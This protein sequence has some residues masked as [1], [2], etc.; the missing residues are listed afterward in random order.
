MDNVRDLVRNKPFSLIR[1]RFAQVC[2][3]TGIV[4]RN[5]L[6]EN[7]KATESFFSFRFSSKL[8]K[9]QSIIFLAE[10]SKTFDAFQAKVAFFPSQLAPIRGINFSKT[11]AWFIKND[12]ALTE[13][14]RAA[15]NCGQK[16]RDSQL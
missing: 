5:R 2:K 1:V 10:N 14:H 7:L 8:K 16:L 15:T 12:L 9:K 3:N 11:Q 4:L 13:T 6:L